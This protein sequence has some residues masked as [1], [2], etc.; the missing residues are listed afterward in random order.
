MRTQ[1]DE[2]DVHDFEANQNRYLKVHLV[3]GEVDIGTC[4]NVDKIVGSGAINVDIEQVGGLE[5]QHFG[6]HIEA[7]DAHA[8][9]DTS[10]EMG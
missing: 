4:G 2:V 3:Q 10:R 8:A 6:L 5:I 1:G 9:K 7:T